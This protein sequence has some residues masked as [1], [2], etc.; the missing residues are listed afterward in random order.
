[1]E[2]NLLLSVRVD[3]GQL[4]V[5]LA[6]QVPVSNDDD[7]IARLGED[8]EGGGARSDGGSS[9][10]KLF[11]ELAAVLARVGAAFRASAGVH[12]GQLA[13]ENESGNQKKCF[14]SRIQ[15]KNSMS[16]RLSE[17]KSS[18]RVEFSI[19]HFQL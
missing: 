10:L 18:S 12:R 6:R 16:S 11:Q 15:H 13:V 4:A 1:M 9:A 8:G 5:L 17:S 2:S 3:N 19:R 7:V 14:S